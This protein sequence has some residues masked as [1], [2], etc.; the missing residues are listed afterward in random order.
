MAYDPAGNRTTLTDAKGNTIRYAYD[1]NDRL[2]NITYP[3][4]T[5]VSYQYDASGRRTAM[6]DSRGTTTYQYDQ[7]SRLVKEDGPADNDAISY[8]YDAAGNRTKMTNQNGGSQTLR[9]YDS[10]N[11]LKSE[12]MSKGGPT[13]TVYYS[14]GYNYD[15]V[16]NRTS[17]N[18]YQSKP[19]STG[20]PDA[21]DIE[22]GSSNV[23]IAI[24]DTGCE[25]T[26][27]DLAEKFVAGYDFVNNDSDPSDDN[28]HGTFCAGIAAANTNNSVGTA[29]V[30]WGSRHAGEGS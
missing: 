25:L 3:D 2:V 5:S 8:E 21:W 4:G 16:G 27:P 6:T 17:M 14:A 1:E 7:L 22:K 28:G 18:K 26:H 11:R 15:S 23:I 10:L 12:T 29:G 20:K 30:D 13:G 19:A 24:V 9:E